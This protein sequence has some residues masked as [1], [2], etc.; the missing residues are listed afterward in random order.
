MCENC[1]RIGPWNTLEMFLQPKKTTKIIE[2][3]QKLQKS[4]EILPDAKKD[5]NMLKSV[6]KKLD[7]K[8]EDIY[9]DCFKDFNL[10][11]RN[12][13]KFETLLFKKASLL[14]RTLKN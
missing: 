2:E 10:P 13:L 8:S 6:S 3:L 5:W 4:I 9:N 11:V 12:F 7:D 1:H 14:D